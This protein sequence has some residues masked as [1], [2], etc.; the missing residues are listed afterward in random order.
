MNTRSKPMPA[1]QRRSATVEAV[2]ALAADQS[3]GD[4]TT[5][6]IAQQM[7][8]SQAAVFRHFS[9]K[10]K[11]LQ[12]VMAWVSARLLSRVD[13]A[14]ARADAPLAALEAVFKAHVEF[15]AKHPGV[16]KI[17]FAEM[18]R[19][20]DSLA[21]RTVKTLLDRYSSRLQKL[22]A[23]GKAKGELDPDLDITSATVLFIGTIQGL[24]VRSLLSGRVAQ[25]RRDAPG[26]FAIYR[27]GIEERAK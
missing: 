10:E 21:K 3:P 18:Q 20:G 6:A 1:E 7:G 27:R 8:V 22:F 14:I 13:A 23:D 26:A 5:T 9:D 12:T 2:V 25:I 17:L 15:I 24:V 16:P 4:I 19:P 11:I